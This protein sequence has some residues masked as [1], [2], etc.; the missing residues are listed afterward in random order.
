MTLENTLCVYSPSNRWSSPR[1]SRSCRLSWR[2][3]RSFTSPKAPL[4]FRSAMGIRLLS[5]TL[6]TQGKRLPPRRSLL[7]REPGELGDRGGS[8][9]SEL[10]D[11]DRGGGHGQLHGLAEAGP[12]GQGRR[13]GWRSRQSPAPTMSIGPRTGWAGTCS[14][15]RPGKAPTMPCSA[16]VTNTGWPVRGETAAAAAAARRRMPTTGAAGHPR[17][18]GGV[19]LEAQRREIAQAAAA[20]GQHDQAGIRLQCASWTASFTR[21][22]T[23][24]VSGRST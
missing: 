6:P 5:T 24:P 11:H 7:G 3:L 1:G 9:G 14:G 17:Q 13:P 2:L 16:S 20:V 21:S 10:M 4:S 22:V 23:T 15:G 19:H 18:L 8:G 12:C